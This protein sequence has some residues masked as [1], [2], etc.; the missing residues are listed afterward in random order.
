M[1]RMCRRAASV[2]AIWSV[3]MGVAVAHHSYA[4]FDRSRTVTVSGT[5]FKFQWENPHIYVWLQAKDDKNSPVLWGIEGG[6]P[7]GLFRQGW[8]KDSFKAGEHV[9]LSLHP[10]RDG[11]N[12]GY[13]VKAVKDDGTMVGGDSVLEDKA[14]PNCISQQ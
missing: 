5:V 7:I 12:G 6:A 9:L 3:C 8:T 14:T 13:F 11:R 1:S 2:V 10:L 4:L